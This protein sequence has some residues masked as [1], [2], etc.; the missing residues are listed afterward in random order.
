[1]L[2]MLL[3]THIWSFR[4][5]D[6]PNGRKP[7]RLPGRIPGLPE[8][9]INEIEVGTAKRPARIRLTRYARQH[10]Q[11]NPVVLIHGFSANG[12]TFAHPALRPGLAK[13]PVG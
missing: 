11:G 6:A 4:L 8:P 9:Q 1:M 5:P 12:T 2:R 13:L 3:T 7:Q 10:P